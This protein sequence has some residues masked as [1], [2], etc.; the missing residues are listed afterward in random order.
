[1]ERPSARTLA[2]A[3]LL[4]GAFVAA[5]AAA[6]TRAG[7]RLPEGARGP[8]LSSQAVP[9]SPAGGGGASDAGVAVITFANVSGTAEDAWFGAGIAETLAASLES[10]GLR[11]LRDAG[12][13]GPRDGARWT[14]GGGYQ[15]LGDRL[16][17]TARLA[18]RTTGTVVRTAIVDGT[19][20]ELFALQD[21][22]AAE[23]LAGMP[24]AGGSAP[25]MAA[26][27]T[28]TGV[29]TAT[30]PS[31]GSRPA[32]GGEAAGPEPAPRPGAPETAAA[33]PRPAPGE[34]PRPAPGERPRLAPGE[35][36]RLAPGGR[37][38]SPSGPPPGRGPDPGRRA[39]TGAASRPG[40]GLAAAP[41]AAIDGPPAPVA[42]ATI[43]RD[44]AG[45]AT[46][47]A[48]RLAQPLRVDGVLDEG[49]YEI[50]EPVS[51]FLQQVPIEGAPA[52]E[53]TE[54][55]IFFDA[56]NV[57]V[58]AR[59]W[60]S[61][62]ES[63]W[64]ANEMQR[65]S[66][67]LIQNDSFSM[68]FDTFYDRRNGAAFMI[69]PLGGFFDYQITDEGNPNN[70]WNPIWDSRTGRFDGGWT[71]ETRVPFKS[72]RFQPGQ[73]KL[74]GLQLGRTIRRRNESA[75]LTRV[76]ISGGPGMF[77]VSAGATLT[78]MEVP[79]GNR[80]LEV[81]PYAIGGLATD[82]NAVPEPIRNE[83][84]G[85]VGLDVKFGVTENLT[86]DFTYNTDFAQVEVDE[87]QVNLTRFSLF[88]PEKR[89]FFL[90]SRGIFDF[91]RGAFFGGG[92]GGGGGTRRAG[93]F[94]GGGDAPIIFFSRRIGLE[95]RDGI[96]RTVPI[97]GGGRLTGKVGPFSIGALGIRTGS[98]DA[99]GAQPTTFSVLRVSRDILRRS[100]VGA[101]YTH[102]SLS[103]HGPRG[104][105]VYGV[106]GQF[107]F[108][109]NLNFNG[110]YARSRTPDLGNVGDDATYQGV[111]TY[112]GDL[113]AFQ[114]DYLRVGANFNP[115]MGFRR[116]WD[117]RRTFAT[118]QYSPRPRSI[119]AV[120]QFT[121]G[122]S[123]DYIETGAGAVETRIAQAR[124]QTEFEN[125][126]RI[127]F[128]VQDNYELLLWPFALAPGAS[129]EPG[130]YG[131]QD[132]YASYSMGPQRRVSGTLT[133]QQ[134]GFYDGTISAVGYRR[135]R[136]ELTPQ[137][138]LEPGI[139][140]NRIVLPAGEATIPLVTS[141]VTYT[142]TPRMFFG[143]LVQYNAAN[144]SL[145]TNLRLRWEY[146]PGSE[147][148][149]VY[150]DQRETAL[151]RTP[152]LQN[153]AFIIKLTRLF[154]F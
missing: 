35:R 49:V 133:F 91:G 114:V 13:A 17:I 6:E 118:A 152:F 125:S 41:T 29:P 66:F 19:V 73:S 116:R 131:F 89:E 112:N 32:V 30:P 58:S 95:Q 96:S 67:Q 22:L 80:V 9:G 56:E 5:A 99:V 115:E 87:Q 88:F 61:S 138:S 76:P 108:F 139:S 149:A 107:A 64:I 110:Y 132:L 71:V 14:I 54:A 65:D 148:F 119:E 82:V 57:Y 38:P 124:F 122:A 3:S 144:S 20:A 97:L 31:A 10:E 126:D 93:G 42:P 105:A 136:V 81:K 140:I 63:S 104:N 4:A 8:R 21:R 59:L 28:G 34:R 48:V 25:A 62:P 72:L 146:Q 79:R 50:V 145:S 16:R 23:L 55:W 24:L 33:R 11:V 45:R 103:E 51:G 78:G 135:P 84:T 83:G 52:T 70:D 92:G 130:A 7:M 90:E 101:I 60:D 111:A 85:D 102:R 53:R 69:N 44:A 117:F 134:G 36:L 129:I 39:A 46:V 153:R 154:R 98:Q 106:D 27:T 12:D 137:F 113:Y 121:V 151:D 47:R 40:A 86:A 2:C 123:L 142:L 43:S 147:L 150:N 128:D 120:R 26:A 18:D 68:S 1:M 74:W 141:R 143:G 100:R 77:R 15:R 75:Y 109:E 94:F 127:S 37:P